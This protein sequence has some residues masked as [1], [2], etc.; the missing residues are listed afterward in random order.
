MSTEIISYDKY[1][2]DKLAEVPDEVIDAVIEFL[3]EELPR[4]SRWD[5]CAQWNKDKHKF[6]EVGHQTWGKIILRRMRDEGL[7]DDLVPDANWDD[8]YLQI[9]EI[10]IG[11]RDRPKKNPDCPPAA[12]LRGIYKDFP[13]LEVPETKW[14]NT[15]GKDLIVNGAKTPDPMFYRID[16]QSYKVW[17]I[18]NFVAFTKIESCIQTEE[19]TPSCAML[20]VTEPSPT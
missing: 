12:L 19:S 17:S 8:Y 2:N 6:G 16:T 1:F 7:T 4:Q 20:E 14:V 11:V 9:I 13:E 5:L 15:Q 3:E 10:F 18:Q